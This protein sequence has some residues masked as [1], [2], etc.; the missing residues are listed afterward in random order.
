VR[1][2]VVPADVVSHSSSMSAA[3]TRRAVD[4]LRREV[5]VVASTGDVEGTNDIEVVTAASKLPR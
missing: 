5:R 1:A 4:V 2:E 3:A